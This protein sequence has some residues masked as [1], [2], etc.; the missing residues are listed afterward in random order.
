MEWPYRIITD[1][2]PEY[3]AARRESLDAFG[4]YAHFSALIPGLVYLLA[5]F[6]SWVLGRRSSKRASYEAIPPSG[7]VGRSSSGRKLW[8]WLSEPMSS[9]G[10]LGRRDQW[11]FGVAW[12]FWLLTLC[13][14]GT[15]EDYAHVTKRFGIIAVSQIPVQTLLSLKAI[16]PFARVFRTSHEEINRFHRTLGYIIY[17][18]LCVHVLL[19]LNLFY[20][21]NRLPER[22]VDEVVLPGEMAM[23]L[24]TTLLGTS[25]PKARQYS[26]RIFFV[27]HLSV[28]FLS[29]A[30][31]LVHAKSAQFYITKALAVFVVDLVVRKITTSTAQ[32]KVEVVP[33]TTLIKVT[34]KLPPRKISQFAERPG[35]HV[36]LSIPWGARPRSLYSLVYEFCFNPFTVAEVR[37][38]AGEVVLVARKQD[39]PM[40][41]RLVKLA[42]EGADARIPLSIEGPFGAFTKMLPSLVDSGVDRVL[43]VAGGVGASFALPVYKA[44]KRSNPSAKVELTWAVR[45]ASDAGWASSTDVTVTNGAASTPT[46]V[47]DDPDVHVFVTGKYPGS[48]DHYNG[49]ASASS[50]VEMLVLPR[51]GEGARRGSQPL[52]HGRGR[53]DLKQIVDD[54][55]RDEDVD[56]KVAVLVCG[57]R[58]MTEVVKES[59]A[60][61]VRRGRDVVWH[62]ENFGW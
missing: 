45:T 57:P 50:S 33:G 10:E 7:R 49:T 55:F 32:A 42:E 41:T 58:G 19:Y 37:Q 16:N 12:A 38:E 21:L 61:W 5:R 35:A 17:L 23:V 48:S 29:S 27:T 56:A 51:A 59:V 22:L 52:P 15:G 60:P 39:G 8:W 13:I 54:V 18:F 6:G 43:L 36:Y 26:Y 24:F 44:L 4:T 3:K 31:L 30:F 34:A 9:T 25:L 40:T 28:V 11:V 46:D 62:G 20:Q 53:P 47:L 1:L 14:A 2:T